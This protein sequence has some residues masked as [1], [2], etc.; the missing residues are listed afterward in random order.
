MPD[1]LAGRSRPRSR[2]AMGV[3]TWGGRRCPGAR[4]SPG[5]PGLAATGGLRPRPMKS[6]REVRNP[7][8]VASEAR[9][10]IALACSSQ[11]STAWS[12]WAYSISANRRL[13]WVWPR[14]ASGLFRTHSRYG[15]SLTCRAASVRFSTVMSQTSAGSPGPAVRIS[16]EVRSPSPSELIRRASSSLSNRGL[17]ARPS[18]KLPTTGQAG[19]SPEGSTRNR[20]RP[21]GVEV[22]V[23]SPG[24]VVAST[25]REDLAGR[26]QRD[27]CTRCSRPTSPTPRPSPSEPGSTG[28]SRTGP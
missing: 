24:D 11:A 20:A 26:V 1:P 25:L 4:R 27:L 16:T 14:S 9:T 5:S 12:P 3:R 15:T 28:S 8:G 19:R 22:V 21:E 7:P 23:G 2:L 10:P 18:G 13:Y 17:A 6:I